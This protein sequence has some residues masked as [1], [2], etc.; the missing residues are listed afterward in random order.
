MREVMIK[1][2]P[3]VLDYRY[4]ARGLCSLK[5]RVIDVQFLIE[6]KMSQLDHLLPTSVDIELKINFHEYNAMRSKFN[7]CMYLEINWSHST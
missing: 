7:P 5:C 1:A 6:S 3:V 2:V 4:R